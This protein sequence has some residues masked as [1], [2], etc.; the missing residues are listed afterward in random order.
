MDIVDFIVTM[1]INESADDL[2]EE[3]LNYSYLRNNFERTIN[4]ASA[5]TR[6]VRFRIIYNK[7]S[8]VYTF[9]DIFKAYKAKHFWISGM[10]CQCGAFYTQNGDHHYRWCKYY[11]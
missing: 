10:D 5:H 7:R 3:I 4:K 8:K 6:N 9:L 1:D 2:L 11:V